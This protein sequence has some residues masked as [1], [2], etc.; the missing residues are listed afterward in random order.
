VNAD[1]VARELLIEECK[2]KPNEKVFFAGRVF[3][4]AE[5]AQVLEVLEGGEVSAFDA[6]HITYARKCAESLVQSLKK[7]LER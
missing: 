2:S 4:Y 5:L 6:P 1:K 7:I 3:T